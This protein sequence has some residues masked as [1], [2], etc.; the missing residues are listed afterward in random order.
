MP[1]E[2]LTWS[3]CDGWSN[4]WTTEDDNGKEI[5]VVFDT[6]GEATAEI[7]GEISDTEYAIG[8][9]YM[10]EGARVTKND[11]KIVEAGSAK[12]GN[13]DDIPVFIEIKDTG[14]TITTSVPV[15]NY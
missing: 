8:Q 13:T 11:F 4:T 7:D 3:L 5:P 15:K 1:Y 6:V 12:P 2:V 9:G 10:D 14:E